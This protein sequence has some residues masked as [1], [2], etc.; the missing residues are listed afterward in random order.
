MK[1]RMI[2]RSRALI[3]EPNPKHKEPWQRGRKGSLCPSMP[4]ALVRS[5]LANSMPHG[6]KRYACYQEQAYCAQEHAQ[7]RWHGYP[8]A[9]DEVPPQIKNAWIAQ[10]QVTK[11]QTKRSPKSL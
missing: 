11:S 4:L 7:G 2:Y 6:N 5:L 1:T 10:E 3:Y 8:V 9:W